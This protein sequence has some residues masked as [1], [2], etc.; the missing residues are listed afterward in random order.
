MQAPKHM[1][2]L[3]G[4][5][6]ARPVRQHAVGST[7]FLLSQLSHSHQEH[8][9]ESF[10]SNP[11]EFSSSQIFTNAKTTWCQN[12]NQNQNPVGSVSEKGWCPN[13]P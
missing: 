13:L 5:V 11:Q 1:H 10:T 2:M 4:I 7:Y 3:I 6:G 8:K 12:Q 9:F